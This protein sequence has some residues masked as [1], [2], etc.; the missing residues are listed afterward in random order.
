MMTFP[1]ASLGGGTAGFLL[2]G[3][4]TSWEPATSQTRRN[5]L[6]R[7]LSFQRILV[8]TDFTPPSK[9]ALE[10]ALEL[11]GPSDASI[12]LLHVIDLNAQ[13]PAQEFGPAERLMADLWAD[14]TSRMA[15][16]VGAY[17]P[18]VPAQTMLVEGLPWEQIVERS[19]GFDLLVMGRYRTRPG[20][21]LFAKHTL[22]RVVQNARCP[23]TVVPL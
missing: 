8:P 22:E 15:D 4:P 17:F 3:E 1:Q 10:H 13:H 18:Q 6:A 20:W 2:A 7:T 19:D 9:R 14:G 12:T 23:V 5:G 21:R 16:W 11:A